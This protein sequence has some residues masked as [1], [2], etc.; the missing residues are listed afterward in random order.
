MSEHKTEMQ[1]LADDLDAE[2]AQ[3]RISNHAG[4]KAAVDALRQLDVENAELRE[5]VK[6]V[7]LAMEYVVDTWIENGS[8]LNRS[9]SVKRANLVLKA[10]V[11]QA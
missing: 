10:T 4:R 6:L 8:E 2:F 11:E 3:G 7:D 1:R 5:W 9:D